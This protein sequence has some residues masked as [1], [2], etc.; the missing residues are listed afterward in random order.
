MAQ[1]HVLLMT[2]DQ[3]LATTFSDAFQEFGIEAQFSEDSEQVANQLNRARYEGV[4]FDSDTVPARPALVTLHESPSNKNAILFV[5]ATDGK[6]MEEALQNRA[7][8]VLR[9][10]IQ[11]GE[12]RQT[13]RVA[14]DL[15]LGER[16][17]HFRC[18]ARLPVRLTKM[19]SGAKIECLTINVSSNG[20]AVISPTTLK[21]A[22]T[23]DV[24]LQ[25]PDGFTV[26]ATGIVIWDDRHGKAG[27]HFRCK[28]PEMRQKLDSW[29]DWQFCSTD[30]PQ[31]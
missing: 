23:L 20:L 22:E 8:F 30:N 19:T 9:R 14:Y 25:M 5:V 12:I 24:A 6:K 27:L 3:A 31:G 7:H 15:M 11:T 16:R 18:A 2:A 26:N 28:S 13:L 10:P 29:L 1:I 4:I 17:R 21:V